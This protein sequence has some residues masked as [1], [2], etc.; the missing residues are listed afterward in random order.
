MDIPQPKKA[1]VKD[2]FLN[3]TYHNLVKIKLQN[4]TA[5]M[6]TGRLIIVLTFEF[7]F[8]IIIYLA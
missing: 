4:E 3:T 2:R 1:E 8:I 7:S 5:I 6:K